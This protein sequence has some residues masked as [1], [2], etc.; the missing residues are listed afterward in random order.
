MP[1]VRGGACTGLTA[2]HSSIGRPREDDRSS[3][4]KSCAVVALWLLL[5]SAFIATVIPRPPVSGFQTGGQF[6]STVIGQVDFLSSIRASTPSALAHPFK[7]TFDS[8]GNLWV[9]DEDNNRVLEFRPPFTDGMNASL[10]IGQDNLDSNSGATTQSQLS[11]PTSVTFDSSGDMWVSDLQNNRV[12]EFK[13]PFTDGMNA[14]LE[15]GQPAGSGEFSTNDAVPHFPLQFVNPH[16]ADEF[17]A[18]IDVAFDH[19]GDLW[20]ADRGNNRVLEFRPPFSDGMNASIVVGQVGLDDYSTNVTATQSRFLGPQS[21]AFDKQ[22]NLW[23]SDENNNRV[24]EF[25]NSSLNMNDPPAA[26]E[27]GQP[28]GAHQF[29]NET[30]A[31][32]SS[33]L[34]GPTF[35]AFDSSGD[36]W[37]SDHLNNRVLGFKPPFKDGE[38]SS[39]VIGQSS[40]LTEFTSSVSA[41]NQTGLNNPLGLGFDPSGDL[42]VAD[43][44]NYRVLEFSSSAIV[45]AGTTISISNATERAN[46]NGQSGQNCHQV[47]E[48]EVCTVVADQSALTGVKVAATGVASASTANVYTA[49]LG[50]QEPVYAEAAQGLVSS[51]IAFYENRRLG[52]RQRHYDRLHRPA[53]GQLFFRPAIPSQRQV[54]QHQRPDK[55]RVHRLRRPPTLRVLRGKY[56]HRGGE[57]Y[58]IRFGRSSF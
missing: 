9:A 7:P 17:T 54:G 20:V 33:T 38:S 23:V 58:R 18:P 15:L 29:T 32:T 50:P 34:D 47:G 3:G 52:D 45:T 4:I 44:S 26:L 19:Q 37:V 31:D 14:S 48:Q 41:T 25:A 57:L 42:W 6:A 22:G 13:P 1:P 46:Q 12:L 53:P 36:L 5:A 27:L 10:V 43:E 28:P 16:L 11:E 30:A 51:P 55:K 39:F 21:L 49:D 8:S 40:G 24:L 35:I 2:H 56:G